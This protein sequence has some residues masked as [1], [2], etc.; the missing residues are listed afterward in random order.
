LQVVVADLVR[1]SEGDL[2]DPALG[3]GGS[4]EEHIPVRFPGVTTRNIYWQVESRTPFEVQPAE[5]LQADSVWSFR[6]WLQ[7]NDGFGQ[8]PLDER[9]AS[10]KLW[11]I[12]FCRFRH[13]F[14]VG[15]QK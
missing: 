13:G 6:G 11:I 14:G 1:R 9:P 3:G 2:G 5:M 4:R 12:L 8:Q 15:E 10:H 7:L